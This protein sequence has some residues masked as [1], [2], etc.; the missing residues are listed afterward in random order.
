MKL[1]DDC[2]KRIWDDIE[3]LVNKRCRVGVINA[4]KLGVKNGLII[5]P[6]RPSD[7][8][9]DDRDFQPWSPGVETQYY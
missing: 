2:D 8:N 3:D 4:F 1:R 7:Y 5:L 9:T 6:E